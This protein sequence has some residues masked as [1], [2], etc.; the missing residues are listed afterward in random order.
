MEKKTRIIKVN[1]SNDKKSKIS[2]RSNKRRYNTK[3]MEKL[4]EIY[5][6][7]SINRIIYL[8]S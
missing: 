1:N 5:W 4:F 8:Y 3:N 7:Y 2:D 6:T